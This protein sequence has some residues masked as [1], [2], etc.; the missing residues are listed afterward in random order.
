MKTRII[1]FFTTIALSFFSCDETKEAKL[2]VQNLV[3]NARLQSIGYSNRTI[4]SSLLPGETS[5]SVII[6][7]DPE[8]WPMQSQLEFY[9]VRNNQTVYLKTKY[10]FILEP[11]E[12]KLIVIADTTQV[13]SPFGKKGGLLELTIDL[14]E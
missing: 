7:D 10:S 13:I 1:I 14:I 2:S 12:N 3:H 8:N 11:D 9:M 5:G 4:S 6:Y